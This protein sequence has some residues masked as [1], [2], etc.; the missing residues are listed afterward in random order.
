MDKNKTFLIIIKAF[1]YWDAFVFFG[2]IISFFVNF[3]IHFLHFL[4]NLS[5]RFFIFFAHN[6]FYQNF[7]Y[8]LSRYIEL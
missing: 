4:Q 2:D 1:H 8:H 7:I 5:E 6:V 3:S